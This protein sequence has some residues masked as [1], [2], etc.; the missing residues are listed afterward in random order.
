MDFDSALEHALDGES[1]L[2]LGAGFSLGAINSRLQPFE[3]GTAFANRLASA[4]GLPTP[5]DLQDAAEVFLESRGPA[6]L[7]K[8]VLESFQATT[9]AKHHTSIGSVP[10]RRVYTTN[11]D[12]VLEIASGK[13]AHPFR[14]VTL[15]EH[16]S[17]FDQN[18]SICVHFNGYVERVTSSLGDELKLTDSSYIAAT[19]EASPWSSVFRL[20]LS[21]AKSVFFVGYSLVDLDIARLL[22][23]TEL[24]QEKTFFVVGTSPSRQT[25]SRAVR[26]GTPKRFDS[27]WFGKQLETKRARYSPR[28]RT[29]PIWYCVEPYET[30]LTDTTAVSDRA[31]FDLFLR[32]LVDRQLAWNS[33]HGSVQPYMVQRT[34]VG[35]ILKALDDPVNIVIV[36]GNL[37]NGKSMVV[38]T[39]AGLAFA[40]GRPVYSLSK[41]SP[42]MEAELSHLCS[43]DKPFLLIIDSYPGWMDALSTLGKHRNKHMSLLLTARTGPNDVL[44][45]RIEDMFRM[46]LVQ[47]IDIERMD[48]LELERVNEI[49]ERYGLWGEK[50]ALPRRA[51]VQSL[52]SRCHGEWQSI[53]VD[54]FQ[55]PQIESRFSDVLR[56]LD[57]KGGY[58]DVLLGILALTV[59]SQRVTIDTLAD[60]FGNRVLNAA[61][62]RNERV[63]EFVNFRSGDVINRSSVA[64]RFVLSRI[65]DPN[66]TVDVLA[67]MARSLDKFGTSYR[68]YNETLRSLLQFSQIEMILPNRSLSERRDAA[69]RYY[70][71]VKNLAY[72]QTNPQ[73]WLQYAIAALVFEDFERADRYFESAYS[74]ARRQH[75]YD[76]HKIDNHYARLLLEKAC[77]SASK[78][79]GLKLFRDARKIIFEQI[80]TERL[81]YPYRVATRIGEFYD[82]F[83]GALADPEREEILNAARYIERRINGLPLQLRQQRYVVECLATMVRILSL[84]R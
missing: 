66:I 41:R 53:L 62:Q 71:R 12:N 37:G 70:E 54:L 69:F 8:E 34:C 55:A 57:T 21:M 23:S 74:F 14:P 52:R 32:G 67:G 16:P 19:I 81:H 22:A 17:D 83:V 76:T 84:A 82:T 51:R 40:A 64:A 9:V 33:V 31:I 6:A 20:D 11:Y 56:T 2:F 13:S 48:E 1:V 4:V 79:I 28:E 26:Y 73:F 47:E 10:W 59:L 36:H 18:E 75:S 78:E 38:E 7:A 65:A 15:S 35:V 77:R 49:F 80:Q 68:L 60:L 30:R 44:V 58:Y 24:L 61:F 25:E 27:A 46:R 50:S 42:S 72:C 5:T 39:V 63:A 45:D 3:L 29:H 43:S